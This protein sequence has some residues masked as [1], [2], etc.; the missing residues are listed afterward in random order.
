MKATIGSVLRRIVAAVALAVG[1]ACA[2]TGSGV[3]FEV[4][5][6]RPSPLTDI[7]QQI[8]S[9][10]L[11]VGVAV[12]QSRVEI[13]FLTLKDL[14]AIAYRVTNYRVHGP[15]WMENDRWDVQAKLPEGAARDQVPEM[16][17]KLLRARFQLQAHIAAKEQ[18]VYCLL[19][20]DRGSLKP[21][22]GGSA[23]GSSDDKTS[24]VVRGPQGTLAQSADGD[25]MILS[26]ATFGK[27]RLRPVNPDGDK[28]ELQMSTGMAKLVEALMLDQPVIDL[29]GLQGT[30]EWSLVLPDR[31]SKAIT[32]AA[33]G[34]GMIA[35]PQD[36]MDTVAVTQA[37][38]KAG[39]KLEARKMPID[40]VVVDRVERKPT[41]N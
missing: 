28:I 4:A 7:G 34:I 2:Q 12:N 6:I 25:A 19:V 5:S 39:L 40:V 8:S 13:N 30:Y 17:Q 18:R 36:V 35:G 24:D 41:E 1:T 32:R 23:A 27:V 21:V 31:D 9:G 20:G 11:R 29:T 26:S 14:I 33:M 10:Q 38:Q 16:L 3:G 15:S 37:L 22:A